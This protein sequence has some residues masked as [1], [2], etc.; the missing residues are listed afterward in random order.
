MAKFVDV[1]VC[2]D[3]KKRHQSFIIPAYIDGSIELDQLARYFPGANGLS[4]KEGQYW[5]ML[6]LE[7][8]RLRLMPGQ[9]WDPDQVYLIQFAPNS[10]KMEYYPASGKCVNQN[11]FCFIQTH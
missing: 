8:D 6:R 3:I 11:T 9:S 10:P 2:T 1:R 4:Y 7:G 5:V